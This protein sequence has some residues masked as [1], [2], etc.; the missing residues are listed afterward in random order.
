MRRYYVGLTRAKQSLAIHT[1]GNLFDT[2][3]NAQQLYDG[4]L[5]TEPDEIVLQLSH[6]DVN[7]GFSKS[8]KNEILALRSGDTLAYH[9]HLLS[10]PSNGRDIAQLSMKMKE[11]LA[12]W[13]LKGYK[14]TT[15]HI[16]F[17]VA[18]KPKDAPKDEKE[19]AIV[20]ADL[21]MKKPK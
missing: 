17:I 5:Y 12:K 16:R 4:Q 3:S 7:L 20:L 18:W 11:R 2:S 13:E 21:V 8:H 19:S 9:D 15:S 10:L 6:K 14:V 1:N